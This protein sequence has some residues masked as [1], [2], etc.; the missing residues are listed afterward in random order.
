MREIS[1]SILSANHTNL[2]YDIELAKRHGCNSIH[3][4]VTDGHYT[5]EL[6]FGVQLVRD[7]TEATDLPLSIHIAALDQERI[8]QPFLTTKAESITFQF[9]PAL[10]P[11]RLIREIRA[12]G[13]KVGIAI[14][15][16]TRYEQVE[17]YLDEIDVINVLCVEPGEGGQRYNQKVSEKIRKIRE[18][19]DQNQLKTKLAVDGGVNHK[20]IEILRDL[21]ADVFIMGSAIFSGASI[22]ENLK[23]IKQQMEGK[24]L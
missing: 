14:T 17:Y 3:V 1:A 12:H 11:E 8:I 19:L 6:I 7:L 21:G 13:K 5:S 4:D 9:E 15:P 24:E 2:A 22:G 18:Y 23:N 16:A 20:N 10:H